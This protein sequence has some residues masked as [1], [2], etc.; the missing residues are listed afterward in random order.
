M[1]VEQRDY[2][3]H[4]GKLPEL[5]RLYADEGIA[6]QKEVLGGLRRR[7]HHGCRRA[8][9]VHLALELR[10]PRERETRRAA[11]QARPDWQEFLAQS[12]R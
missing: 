2:H 11:L 1:I 6:I 5:V 8:L 10:E 7:V 12:S 3:V 9:D 4:T